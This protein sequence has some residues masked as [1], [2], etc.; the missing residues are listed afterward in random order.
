MAQKV[1]AAATGR[2]WN[3]DGRR[4]MRLLLAALFLVAAAANNVAAAPDPAITPAFLN[5]LSSCSYV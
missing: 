4:R 3:T 2:R 1:G 5:R